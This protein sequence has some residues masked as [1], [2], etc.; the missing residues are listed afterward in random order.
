M[1]GSPA[2]FHPL[3]EP[4]SF[5]EDVLGQRNRRL[6]GLEG[7][8]VLVVV[9]ELRKILGIGIVKNLVVREIVVA[10]LWVV[11]VVVLM[12]VPVGGGEGWALGLK[13]APNLFVLNMFLNF[14]VPGIKSRK[15]R[16][17]RIPCRCVVP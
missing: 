14:L 12:V 15:A 2:L 13:M 3:V 5:L 4:L 16:F 9:P 10:R 8:G 17:L 1:L 7:L 6:W 11:I